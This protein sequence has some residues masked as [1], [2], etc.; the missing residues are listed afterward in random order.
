MN[1]HLTTPVAAGDATL[2]RT[3]VALSPAR[4]AL[5]NGALA[6]P[7]AH[8]DDEGVAI[9]GVVGGSAAE[10]RI[11]Y[12]QRPVAASPEVLALAA[13]AAPAAVFRF[14]GRCAESACRHFDGARCSLGERIVQLLPV[15]ADRLPPCSLR[16]SCRWWHEQGVAACRRCPQVVTENAA[17]STEMAA[18][19]APGANAV[20]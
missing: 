11:G 3:P 5:S 12:L 15:V 20:V 7:S 18:A 19:A 4:V 2:V 8:P 9:F 17:P 14:G 10:P 16:P 6:C 1:D 13:P